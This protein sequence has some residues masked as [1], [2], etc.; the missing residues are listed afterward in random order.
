M[1]TPSSLIQEYLT[2]CRALVSE[3]L[4]EYLPRQSRYRTVL[5]DRMLEYPLRHAK[6]LRPSLCIATCRAFGGSLSQVIPSAVAVELLHNGFLVHDDVEDGSL[7]R[8][9]APTLHTAYGVP[10]AINIGDGLLALALRPL[11]ANTQY[12]GLGK[13]LRILEL[14]ANAVQESV[15]GQAIELDWVRCGTLALRDSDYWHMAYKKTCFY[16]FVLPMQIGGII[17]ETSQAL[18]RRIRK[19]AIYLGI[20]F[21]IHDDI[22]N[23]CAEQKNYGKE[24]GGDL[25]EGKRTLILLHA[26][27]VASDSERQ[28]ACRKLSMSREEK[29]EDDVAVLDNLVR[30]YD[31]IA[32]AQR[33]AAQCAHKAAHLLTGEVVQL[34][35]SIHL[36]F[37]RHL[38]DY[39]IQR[40]R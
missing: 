22:L 23:L 7:L 16:T 24:I 25:W 6:A 14:V 11:L 13:S 20:A 35:P 33:F 19:F 29:R 9:G 36:D 31:S 8:R 38:V 3:H 1:A 15:E 37:L 21:Q 18:L 32:Y 30:K 34:I 28:L 2:E 40:D 5:Y 39:V 26:L 12:V 27:R 17:A 4:S 10:I